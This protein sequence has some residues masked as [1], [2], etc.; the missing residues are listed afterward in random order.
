[1]IQ[2]AI[3]FI[4]TLLVVSVSSVISIQAQGNELTREQLQDFTRISGTIFT[5]P[6]TE[7]IGSP[8]L[9]DDY[10]SG[11][12]MINPRT[13]SE[14]LSLRYN[15]ETNEVEYLKGDAVYILEGSEIN[16]FVIKGEDANIEFK[17]GYRT[18]IKGVNTNTLMRVVYDGNVK[19]LVNYTAKLN[20]D[21][22]NYSSATKTNKY[23]TFKKY[24]L[25]TSGGNF[26]EIN[27]PKEDILSVL[28]NKRD[29]L[30]RF[31]VNNDLNLD[32][33]KDIRTLMLYYDEIMRM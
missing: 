19:L 2:K 16:G 18:D 17:N 4:I 33:E 1:M 29:A 9:N 13:R 21:L 11:Y 28:S 32:Y 8:Y 23:Q 22:A 14:T 5:I 25:V 15:I 12:V 10:Y 31:I 30:E 27:N 3:R 26:H 6:G 24:F 7:T 20:E